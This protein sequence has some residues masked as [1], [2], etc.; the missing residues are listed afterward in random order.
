MAYTAMSLPQYGDSKGSG[1]PD[2]KKTPGPPEYEDSPPGESSNA[3]DNA[4]R[5]FIF[6]NM[7]LSNNIV[8]FVSDDAIRKYKSFKD[9][10]RDSENFKHVLD[11]QK[12]G[13][14]LPLLEA[15]FTLA[16]SVGNSKYATIYCFA[17]PPIDS[18][19]MFD[20]KKDR[21]RFCSVYKKRGSHHSRYTFTF[22]PNPDNPNESFE[23]SIFINQKLPIADVTKFGNNN[24]RY[25]W[26]HSE[27]HSLRQDFVFELY[28][29]D[30]DQPSMV[31]NMDT[32]E[33]KL[34]PRNQLV[35][36]NFKSLFKL[37]SKKVKDNYLS[38]TR[39]GKLFYLK[40]KY[41]VSSFQETA[42]LLLQIPPGGE[43]PNP[44]ST[45]SVGINE[46]IFCCMSMV[47]KRQEEIRVEAARIATTSGGGG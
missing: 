45:D 35:N 12:Q 46:L 18:G 6:C 38:D 36:G 41:I 31:D 29:L 43:D 15:S 2:E 1:Y 20:K 44:E 4:F 27:Y 19:R 10:P 42:K 23:V 22:Y 34:D 17:K 8:T 9:V 28:M 21:Y 47:F 24:D 33:N 11:L 14:G 30:N 39:L 7:N 13:V 40:E 32:A 3:A 5:E 26:V 25:R 37:R 16:P